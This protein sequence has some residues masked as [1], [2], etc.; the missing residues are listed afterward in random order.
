[1]DCIFCKIISG[2]LPC[3]KIFEDKYTFAFLDIAEDADGHTIVV[4][5]KHVKNILDCDDETLGHIMSTIKRISHHYVDACGYQGINL[6]N[7]NEI[8][9]QQSVFH[10]HFHILPRKE[11]DGMNAWPK[12]GKSKNT[13]EDIQKLL[14]IE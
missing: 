7:A 5:K 6:L 1:M 10:L 13:L 3:Y 9:A 11:N 4:P 14:K 12:L 8:S 2:E